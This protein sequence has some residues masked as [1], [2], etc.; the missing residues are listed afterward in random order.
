VTLSVI[1]PVYNEHDRLGTC[2]DTLSEYLDRTF[3]DYEII[4][5]E[6]DSPDG[7]YEVAKA[8]AAGHKSVAVLHNDRRLG[9]GAS[10]SRAIMASKGDRI[11]YMDVD[12]A[13]NLGH[14]KPLVDHIEQ[15]AAIATGSR[16]MKGS[17]VT[18]PMARDVPSRAYN[19]LVRI[20]FGSKIY[21][22]QCGFKAFDRKAVIEMLGFP[23]DEHWFWDTELLVY[24][25]RSGYR[26]DE[27]PVVW[28]HNGGNDLSGSKVRVIKDSLD[29]GRHLLRLKWRLMRNNSGS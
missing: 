1:L 4:I 18:R 23:E 6:D 25:Q 11:I 22:H 10:L 24:A 15:G 28:V 26:V 7:S 17:K 21:D 16:L 27:M 12:L 29:M 3:G 9:R 13:T 5:A 8:I 19:L 2:V 20:L 14:I